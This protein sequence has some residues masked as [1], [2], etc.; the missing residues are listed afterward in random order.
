ME[1]ENLRRRRGI[2]LGLRYIPR[3]MPTIALPVGPLGR[4]EPLSRGLATPE[5]QEL[6]R[7]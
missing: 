3:I 2:G 1:K 4:P 7:I 5:G 6:L